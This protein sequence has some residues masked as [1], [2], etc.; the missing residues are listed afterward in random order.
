M[1]APNAN[2]HFFRRD[3]HVTLKNAFIKRCTVIAVVLF[4]TLGASASAQQ[5]GYQDINLPSQ[6]LQEALAAV[7]KAYGLTVIAPGTLVRGKTSPAVSGRLTAD[8]AVE[9]LLRDSGLE[10]RRNESNA[11]IIHMREIPID[12][13]ETRDG[14]EAASTTSHRPFAIEGI[15]VTANKMEE[16]ITDVPQS[17]TVIDAQTLEAKGIRNVA[18]VINEIPN[19]SVQRNHGNAVSFRGLNY[20]M[21]TNNNP[22][23]IYIDGVPY[24]NRYGF[25]ASMANVER[26]EVL[27]G[28]QSTLYGKDAIGAVINIVTQ[29][30]TNTWQGKVGVEY[31]SNHL[32]QG[33][34]NVGGPL[35][36]DVLYAG[37]NGWYSQNDGWIEN[38]HPGMEKDANRENDRRFSGYLLYKPTDRL[39]AR[40]TLSNDYA[41]KYGIDGY[42]L[43]SGSDIGAFNRDDAEKVDFDVPT[44]AKTQSTAQSLHVAYEFDPVTLTSTSTH[45]RLEMKGDY[46]ADF[47]ASPLFAGL[48]NFVVQDIDTWTQELRVSSNNTKGFRWVG[49]VYFDFEKHEQ[50]PYGMQFPDFD[51]VTYAYLGNFEMNAESKTD[52]NTQAVFGQVMVPLGERFELTLG[53]RY[54]RIE[55]K[56][57]LNMYYLPVG[58]TGPPMFS[59]ND[60]K[61]WDTFLPK[62]ALSYKITDDWTAY[63][64]YSHGYMPGGYNYFAMEGSAEDNSFD[65]QRSTNYELGIKGAFDRFRVAASIFHMEIKDIHVY[66]AIGTMYVTDNAKKAHSQGAELELTYLP[67]DEIELTGAVGFINAEYDDYDA[68]TV[69][70]DG[71]KIEQTPSHTLR[72]SVA[73]HH[74]RGAYARLD[75]K[76]QGGTY[77]YDSANQT[78]GREK[79]YTVADMRAGWRFGDWDIYAY[80]KNLTDE[81]Y[82]TSFTPNSMTS[83]VTFGEPRTIGGGIRYQF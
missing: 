13:T 51:P 24:S 67:L 79:S 72:I 10:A 14:P 44:L 12:G 3:H 29:Q 38:I 55:K 75:V 30:P 47:G 46:D 77:F 35:L 42:A 66:K 82:I 21:F 33:M 26:I 49:G 22:V 25:D 83:I 78:F 62:A 34:F 50:G 28:P 63:A 37:I 2:Q 23:V 19:M 39:S 58:M 80:V 73:Y 43:P 20:S 36:D 6:P 32:M 69:K 16:D 7:G 59:F 71:K 74:P 64:S 4:F 11:L 61:T 70:F 18:D 81:K 48:K 65:P 41:R 56:I 45:R 9:Q 76:N 68:G 40:L 57:D 17:I 27:R 1:S 53:G 52:S 5:S 60:K 8:Q 15:T 31:G 54:Q